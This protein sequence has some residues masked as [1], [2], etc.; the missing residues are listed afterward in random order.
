MPQDAK[1]EGLRVG[2]IEGNHELEKRLEVLGAAVHGKGPD[3]LHDEVWSDF[4]DTPGAETRVLRSEALCSSS[5]RTASYECSGWPRDS[6]RLQPAAHRHA[7]QD[8]LTGR[9]Q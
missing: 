3:V 5:I 1:R 4:A 6:R 9:V 7:P 2:R 8:R